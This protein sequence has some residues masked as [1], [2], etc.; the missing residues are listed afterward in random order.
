MKRQED[1][2]MTAAE[3]G[4]RNETELERVHAWRAQEL[5]RAGFDARSAGKLAARPD[6][7]LHRAIDL[8]R[9]GCPPELALKILL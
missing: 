5:E 1:L 9:L 3:A 6:V 8:L 7:D 4:L 2:E